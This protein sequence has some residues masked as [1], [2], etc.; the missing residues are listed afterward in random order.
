MYVP[1]QYITCKDGNTCNNN[2][3]AP[4]NKIPAIIRFNIEYIA[5]KQLTKFSAA[6]IR[7]IFYYNSTTQW[8][9]VRYRMYLSLCISL[10]N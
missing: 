1:L 2:K 9:Y 6:V 3:L 7:R 5:H 10:Y 8:H 4:V